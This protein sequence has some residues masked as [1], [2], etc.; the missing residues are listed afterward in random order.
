MILF[1]SL[2]INLTVIDKRF[3]YFRV[4]EYISFPINVISSY[5][6]TKF[7]NIS[8]FFRDRDNITK[9]G[10]PRGGNLYMVSELGFQ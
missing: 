4:K 7:V 9:W 6:I 5:L 3:D 10:S 8:S 1:R 2:K